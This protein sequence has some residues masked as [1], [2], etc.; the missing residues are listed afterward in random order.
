MAIS[1]AE[2]LGFRPGD[3]RKLAG[4]SQ[5]TGYMRR[6]SDGARRIRWFDMG[7]STE[8][9]PFF[10][11]CI[12]SQENLSRLEELRE[13]QSLLADPR[14]LSDVKAQE[15]VA[16]A[17][18]VVLI[19]CSIHATEVGAAQMSM[20][21]AHDLETAGDPETLEMLQNVILILIPA[22][23][24]DGLDMV[25]DWYKRYLGTQ[26]EGTSPP[27]LYQKYAGHDNN[28]DWFMLNL[29]ENRL[30]VEKVHHVWHPHIVFDLHQMGD[31]GFRFFVPPYVDPYDPNVD[32]ILRQQIADLGLH[33]MTELLSSGKTGVSCCNGFD[34][35]APA[36]AYQHYHGG[37]RILSEAAS[38]KLATPVTRG[39]D[40]L[41]PG[42][43]GA[44]PKEATWNHPVPWEGGQW[45]LRDIVDY[46][47]IAAFGCLRHAGKFRSL[48]V[49]N[50]LGLSRRACQEKE[51]YAFVFPRDQ[52]DPVMLYELL[53]VL[54]RG[55]VEI[56]RADRDFEAGGA[57][58]KEGSF[59]IKL[60]QPYGAFAKTLL[61]I[62]KYPDLRQY[63]GGPPKLPYD[64]TGHT[65]PLMMNV[66]AY[67]ISKP[68]S[69]VMTKVDSPALPA[70]TSGPVQD[71]DDSWLAISPTVNASAK[72]VNGLL[73]LGHQ[74]Y[75]TFVSYEDPKTGPVDAGTFLVPGTLAG[76]VEEF[77]R[78]YGVSF[79]L[80]SPRSSVGSPKFLLKEPRVAV[81]KSY[82]PIADEGWLRYVL[83]EYGFK[84]GSVEN[85]RLRDGCLEEELDVVI[86]PSQPSGF[87][88][89]GNKAGA[90][91]PEFSGGLG[92]KGRDS[93]ASFIEKGGVCVFLDA[94]C[95]WA[96]EELG[97]PCKNAVAGLK[98]QDFFAPG[99]LLKV[100][101]DT[102]HPLG[103]GL[104]R[105]TAVMFSRSPAW[106]LSGGTAAAR[107]PSGDPLMSG[108]LLGAGFLSDKAAL[109]EFSVGRGRVI[110]VGFHPHFRAQA[111]GTYKVIFNSVYW[112]SSVPV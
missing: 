71:A 32:Y 2:Y 80:I 61:E 82:R 73:G 14:G 66:A 99:S 48:W 76:L 97:L 4:W 74:V 13:T 59:V 51:P 47:K 7:E 67:Q 94:A 91:P 37:V 10:Y 34:A 28:R 75:R 68:F 21:L 20:E 15:L 98:P 87:L 6:L 93:V 57:S 108:W 56:H 103:F 110:L 100:I 43:D 40:E 109:A 70:V 17:K 27:F 92:S 106:E 44:D 11:L 58:F 102:E 8:G 104:S 63:P 49:S 105:E 30:A 42:R 25:V 38:V 22:L 3:D 31:L 112:A 46:E 54:H 81:Y 35:F 60:A 69:C 89:E 12:S 65:L 26:W 85:R 79:K 90:C 39:K 41:R 55:Q 36:R 64:I 5:I 107:Y 50:F 33:M 1:P 84:Y 101:V 24:P 53:K 62:Q 72:V 83:S 95:D 111:R 78:K 9:R 19:S 52:K 23:N 88:R 29:V 16:K 77:C 86:F 96:V 45:R 18:T